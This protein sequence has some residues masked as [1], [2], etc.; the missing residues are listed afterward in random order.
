MY[1]GTFQVSDLE[2]VI[3]NDDLSKVENR[4]LQ[5]GETTPVPTNISRA[6]ATFND[7][8]A[9]YLVA[10]DRA[11]RL[12]G[13]LVVYYLYARLGQ[14]PP[15]RATAYNDS[16]TEL[17]AIRDGKF[18]DMPLDGDTTPAVS[19]PAPGRYGSRR[20]FHTR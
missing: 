19:A 5:Q 4:L 16:M 10:Q 9:K 17:R 12:I 6:V 2:G 7:H 8:T 1:Q 18:P 3:S 14:V 20:P 15:I 11:N 13:T